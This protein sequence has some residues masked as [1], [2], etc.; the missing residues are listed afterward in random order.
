MDYLL[1]PQIAG[2]AQ[3]ALSLPQPW[4]HSFN[5]S[6]AP[7]QPITTWPN[8]VH[9]PGAATTKSMGGTTFAL[10]PAVSYYVCVSY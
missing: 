3:Y 9:G 6:A 7:Q 8:M 5:Y 10:Q 1:V 2:Y 4:N